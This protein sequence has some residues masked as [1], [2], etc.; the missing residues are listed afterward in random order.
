MR[1]FPLYVIVWCVLL[2]LAWPAR[3]VSAADTEENDH[4]IIVVGWYEQDGYMREDS[5]GQLT[6]FGVDYLKAIAY[7]TGWEYRFVKGSRRQCLTW[8]ESGQIDLM[9][10]VSTT[11]E[12]NNAKIARVVIGDDYGYIYKLGNNFSLDYGDALQMNNVTLGIKRDSGVE[13]NLRRYCEENQITFYEL[14][15]FDSMEEMLRQLANEKVDAIVTDSFVNLSDLKVVGRFFNGQMTFASSDVELLGQ[16]NRA[17]EEIK[18]N[19]PSFTEELR[20]LYFAEA[21]HNDLEY[22]QEEKVF[23]EGEKVYNVA[24][25]LDQYPVCYQTGANQGYKGIAIEILKK[26]EYHTGLTF[27]IRYV[28]SYNQ[29]IV[30]LE[31]GEVD[32]LGSCILPSSGICGVSWNNNTGLPGEEYTAGFY[33]ANMALIGERSQKIE[34]ALRVAVPEWFMQGKEKLE[35]L[36][37]Q[38]EYIIYEN[39]AACFEAILNKEVDAAIQSDLKV[40]EVSIYKKYKEIQ[41]LKYIPGSYSASFAVRDDEAL[42]LGILDKAINSISE[43]SKAAIF[44]NNIQHISIERFSFWE[45]IFQYKIYLFIGIMMIILLNYVHGYY[46]KYKIELKNKE[47]AYRDSIANISSME[48]FRLDVLPILQGHEKGNYYALAV[49]VDKFKVIND[50]YGYDQG[51]RV[52][53]FLAKMLKLGLTEKDYITRNHA[54][55]FV[56]FKYSTSIRAVEDYLRGVFEAIEVALINKQTHY[57]LVLKAGIYHLEGNDDILSS[58]IDKASLAK[59]HI[60]HIHRSTYRIYEE[61]MRQENIY[62]KY[63][64]NEMNDALKTGQFCIYLQPQVDFK[65]KKVVSAEALVRWDHPRDGMIP[66]S[67][68]LPIFEKNGFINCLDFYVWEQAIKTIADW[69]RQKKIMVPIAI[70]LSRVDVQNDNMASEL[71]SLMDKYGLE[72]RWIK[73]ELTESICLEG[74]DLMMER[75]QE[76]R[77]LGLNIAVDDFGSGY[78]SLHMLKKMPID[79]LKIDKSFLDFDLDMDIRDEIIIRDIVEMG[80]HLDLQ[81]IA[82]GVETQEQSNF[83]ESIGCDIA[84][85]YFY[86]KPMSVEDFE[87]LLL[88]QYGQGGAQ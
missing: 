26:I 14:V 74:D 42:L 40:N 58:I 10:P 50:L 22:S 25:C 72:S 7:Y 33:E 82:E 83:L 68:F 76:L 59:G 18:M 6:G 79:I 78:S 35:E 16:L 36:Y 12:L 63:L 43:G 27:E 28:D 57:H 17:M 1:R 48:K 84:Q 41:N 31:E 65:T 71:R 47:I 75:M 21:S 70:N 61:S 5:N 64:E 3:Q 52:I 73:T 9:S 80:K 44:N 87:A 24:L 15:Y 56:I 49:D 60:E 37:P 66:P 45:F 53:A 34:D 51:D 86:G 85:G 29:G 23:L 13:E 30:L 54:D 69:R 77:Q 32:I 62:A 8:L 88:K 38:Y 46:R 4:R 39:D 67:R 20:N 11:L 81:I 2:F 55:N 19:N